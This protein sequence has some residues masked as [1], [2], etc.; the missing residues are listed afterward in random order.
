MKYQLT[1][2]GVVV[3]TQRAPAIG[4]IEC[5]ESVHCGLL[6]DGVNYSIPVKSQAEIDAEASE[7]EAQTLAAFDTPVMQT[8]IESMIDIVGSTE[9]PASLTAKIKTKHKAKL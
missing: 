5:D 2:K 8:M 9:T 3:Q 4:F 7:K 1:E 6:F